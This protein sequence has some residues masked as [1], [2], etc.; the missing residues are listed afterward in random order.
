M[1][2]QARLRALCIL[3]IV[4][5]GSSIG[6][7]GVEDTPQEVLPGLIFS[8]VTNRG[9]SYEIVQ[10]NLEQVECRFHWKDDHGNPIGSLSAL[11]DFDFATN[12]GIYEPGLLPAGLYVESGE[13]LVPLNLDEGKGN[14]FLKPN[15]VFAITGAKANIVDAATYGSE[16]TNPD[17]AIQSGPLL[18][19][20]GEIHPA[21]NAESE[22]RYI[23]SGVGVQSP[24]RI[25]FAL[26]EEP[27]T[28]YEFASLFRD[29]LACANALYLDGAISTFAY[30]NRPLPDQSMPYATMI[31]LSPRRQP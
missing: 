19:K 10:A 12:G 26:S 14:F 25:V 7:K 21:F 28:F 17:Y 5:S 30:A 24:N 2:H 1:T 9:V 3:C 18:V 29:E 31:T 6:C 15:G 23:R 20:D 16:T 27:V 22:N 11:S 13:T 8:T 4:T